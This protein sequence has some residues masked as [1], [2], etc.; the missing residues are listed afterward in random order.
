[1]FTDKSTTI[2]SFISAAAAIS[3]SLLMAASFIHSTGSVQWMGSD[4]LTQPTITA[5][6]HGLG[7]KALVR[8]V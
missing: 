2:R 5:H 1:M 3:M 6:V 7:H 4:A 8:Y